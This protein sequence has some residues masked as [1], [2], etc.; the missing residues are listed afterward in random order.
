MREDMVVLEQ[1][2]SE[3]I[4]K[5]NNASLINMYADASDTLVSCRYLHWY[6]LRGCVARMCSEVPELGGLELFEPELWDQPAVRIEHDRGID[7]LASYPICMFLLI[8]QGSNY[9]YVEGYPGHIICS[10]VSSLLDPAVCIGT[11][12]SAYADTLAHH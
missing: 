3:R 8:P 7:V 2:C 6:R 4:R 12:V 1:S 10:F 5:R 11:L 9:T